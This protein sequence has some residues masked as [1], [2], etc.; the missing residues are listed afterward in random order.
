MHPAF[1]SFCRPFLC[2]QALASVV[3]CWQLMPPWVLGLDAASGI[4][5]EGSFN[6]Y[7]TLL[8]NINQE[9]NIKETNLDHLGSVVRSYGCFL[10]GE[11]KVA[12]SRM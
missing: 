11:K 9:V 7:K 3:I 4:V 10:A 6:I 5:V 2:S 1:A 8:V 12:S